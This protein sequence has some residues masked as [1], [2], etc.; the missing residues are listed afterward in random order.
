MQLWPKHMQPTDRINSPPL[1]ILLFKFRWGAEGLPHMK[2][3]AGTSPFSL[4][5]A[6]YYKNR[7]IAT[8]LIKRSLW[9]KCSRHK[10]KNVHPWFFGINVPDI[11]PK[12]IHPWFFG[13]NVPDI[14]KPA[15]KQ[16]FFKAPIKSLSLP[17]V[18]LTCS[19]HSSLVGGYALPILDK[20]LLALVAWFYLHLTNEPEE[21]ADYAHQES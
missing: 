16:V 13:I 6:L 8:T 2:S 19:L 9:H 4:G 1:E 3:T 15:V 21:C 20:L 17:F 11:K 10:A 7:R 5:S 18:L 14:K 12:N